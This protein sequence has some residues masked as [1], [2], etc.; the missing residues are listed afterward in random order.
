M[1]FDDP[2]AS[3]WHDWIYSALFLTAALGII[4]YTNW[5]KRQAMTDVDSEDEAI[6]DPELESTD[7]D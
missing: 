2:T 5:Q 3:F 4:A 7:P 6:A 1:N